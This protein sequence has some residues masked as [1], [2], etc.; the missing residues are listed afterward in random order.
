MG[1]NPRNLL[2]SRKFCLIF[3]LKSKLWQSKQG[4]RGVTEYYNEMLILWYELDLCYE[5]VG[6]N[7]RNS[8]RYMK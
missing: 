4:D 3:D 5:E 8:A 7:P 6:E 1:G 2:K